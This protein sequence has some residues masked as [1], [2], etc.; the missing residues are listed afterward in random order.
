MTYYAGYDRLATEVVG[1]FIVMDK[2]AALPHQLQQYIIITYSLS[3][4]LATAV[5]NQVA[6]PQ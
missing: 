3:T 4:P 6:L 5:T 1:F 2:Q